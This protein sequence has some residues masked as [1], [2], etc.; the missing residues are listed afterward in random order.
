VERNR[1]AEHRPH[2]GKAGALEEAAPVGLGDAAEQRAVGVLGILLVQL[3]D[4]AFAA[5]LAPA[6][7]SGGAS[8]RAL[9][10]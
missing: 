9:P 4:T 3:T 8:R 2:R 1:R 7:S 10:P 5:F 6:R